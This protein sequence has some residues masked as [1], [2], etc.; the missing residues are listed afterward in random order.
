MKA[1]PLAVLGAVEFSPVSYPDDRGLFVSTFTEDGFGEAVGR[2]LFPVRQA[3]VSVSGRG[4]VRGVHYTAVS[5]G[6]Q[7]YVHCPRGTALD[8]VVD[9]RVGSPTFG[10]WDS[11]VLDAR[12]FRAVYLPAGVG[13]AFVALEDDTVM[14]YLLSAGYVAAHELAVSVLDPELGLP[15]PD[16]IVPVLSER[17]RLAVTLAEAAER[18]MLPRF[19]HCEET[20]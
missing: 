4:V 5:P 19:T 6:T 18:D 3:S 16:D 11:V 7:K 2:P 20:R 9:L 8:F 10:A 15:L 12:D 13:H 14:S 1:R 17:D